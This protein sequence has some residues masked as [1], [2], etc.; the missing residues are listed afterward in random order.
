ML[1][2]S[3]H[4]SLQVIGIPPVL[5]FLF[6]RKVW[7]LLCLVNVHGEVHDLLLQSLGIITIQSSVMDSLAVLFE[8]L[9][10]FMKGWCVI[11][12]EVFETKIIFNFFSTEIIW[13][14]ALCDLNPS[15]EVEQPASITAA[16]IGYG[17][18]LLM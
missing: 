15:L 11:P 5:D 8:V 6:G 3:S 14:L 7:D 10:T 4:P 18:E 17:Y 2:V 12:S 9:E 1:Q 13:Q 16:H